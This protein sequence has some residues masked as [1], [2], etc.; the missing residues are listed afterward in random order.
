MIRAGVIKASH[1]ISSPFVA[2]LP[3]GEKNQRI[4]YFIHNYHDI[5][6]ELRVAAEFDE[7]VAG[8]FKFNENDQFATYIPDDKITLIES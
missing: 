1:S 6:Y 7:P 8:L 2:S 5:P 3:I 4:S